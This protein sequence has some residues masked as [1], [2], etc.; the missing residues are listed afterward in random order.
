[1]WPQIDGDQG[2]SIHVAMTG[3]SWNNLRLY[4][5]EVMEKILVRGTIFA[6]MSPEQKQQL[7][8]AFQDIE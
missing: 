4:M 7:V 6:R 5:P 2:P 8:E 1:M 3:K